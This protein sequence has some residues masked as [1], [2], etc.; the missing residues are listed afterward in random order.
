MVATLKA[1]KAPSPLNP[2]SSTESVRGCLEVVFDLLRTWGFRGDV[3]SFDHTLTRWNLCSETVGSWVKFVKYKLAAY[4][5]S[6]TGQD[7]PQPLEGLAS[8]RDR[9]NCKSDRSH[10]VL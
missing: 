4:F 5:A 10:V 2:E 8:M 7:L 6:H 1:S 3:R 9:P